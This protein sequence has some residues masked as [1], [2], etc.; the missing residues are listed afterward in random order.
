MAVVMTVPYMTPIAI[1]SSAVCIDGNTLK[2][3]REK[4]NEKSFRGHN[5]LHQSE[6]RNQR[7]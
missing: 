4:E 1:S 7:K 2:G 6:G 5:L 3:K